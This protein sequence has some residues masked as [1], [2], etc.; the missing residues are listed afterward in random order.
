MYPDCYFP[1]VVVSSV[2]EDV[3]NFNGTPAAKGGLAYYPGHACLHDL[4]NIP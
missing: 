1:R 2:I 4:A 3:L